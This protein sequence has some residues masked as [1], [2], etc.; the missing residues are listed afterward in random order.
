[1][2]R[3]DVRDTPLY[4]SALQAYGVGTLKT[5]KGQSVTSP[6]QAK[7]EAGRLTG[8]SY[9]GQAYIEKQKIRKLA[10]RYGNSRKQ[11]IEEGQRSNSAS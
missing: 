11:E 2:K 10:D 6:Q 7:Q 4:K 3:K 9:N 5:E 8:Q 1:M